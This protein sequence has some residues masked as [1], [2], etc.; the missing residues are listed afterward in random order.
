M[1]PIQAAE[2]HDILIRTV[3]NNFDHDGVLTRTQTRWLI[4]A[5][6]QMY[7]E[8]ARLREP[9]DHKELVEQLSAFSDKHKTITYSTD[10]AKRVAA[11]I[12]RQA[13]KLA[14]KTTVADAYWEIIESYKAEN[15]ELRAALRGIQG[16]VNSGALHKEDKMLLIAGY[17]ARALAA[18]EASH[19]APTGGA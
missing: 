1:N 12:E 16:L 9:G 15:A 14:R 2:Q 19:A 3:R 4:E 5:A 7:A 17:A 10:F 13:A 11:Y 18:Q 8:L 6:E